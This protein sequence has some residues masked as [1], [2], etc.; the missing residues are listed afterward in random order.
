M[1]IPGGPTVKGREA[2]IPEAGPRPDSKLGADGLCDPVR[3]ASW[4]STIRHPQARQIAR[5]IHLQSTARAG[6]AA[7]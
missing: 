4:P 1:A 5:L 6:A 3:P 7:S 2:C